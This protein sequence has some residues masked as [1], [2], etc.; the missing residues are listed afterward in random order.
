MNTDTPACRFGGAIRVA[1]PGAMPDLPFTLQ[2]EV[3]SGLCGRYTSTRLAFTKLCGTVTGE[4]DLRG[5]GGRR[6]REGA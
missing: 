1:A 3:D 5:D 6:S 4:Q 2:G